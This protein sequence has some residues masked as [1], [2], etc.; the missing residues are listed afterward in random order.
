M[1]ELIPCHNLCDGGVL[2][3]NI[4]AG[5]VNSLSNIKNDLLYYI[6]SQVCAVPIKTVYNELNL[7]DIRKFNEAVDEL[8]GEAKLIY[9]SDRKSVV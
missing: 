2:I 4:F 5:R 6:N 8:I 3:K 9:H 1:D 7:D